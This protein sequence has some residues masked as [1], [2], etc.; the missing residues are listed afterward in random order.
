MPR[1]HH[2][3]RRIALSDPTETIRD[4][5]ARF[6]RGDVPGVLAALAPDVQWTEAEG[7]PHG[8]T[9]VGRDAVLSNVFLTLAAEWQVFTVTPREFVAGTDIVV[10]LGEYRG[11]CRASGHSFQAPFAHVWRLRDGRVAAFCQ[12]TDTALVQRAVRA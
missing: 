11:T 7:F 3:S 8:G 12:H 2:R 6:E 1:A 4:L 9:Y 5:Y 10:A